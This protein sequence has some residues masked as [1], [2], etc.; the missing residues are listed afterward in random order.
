MSPSVS[1]L[2]TV[3]FDLETRK[4]ASDVGGWD[5]MRAGRGGISVLVIWDSQ[6][7]RYHL[8]DETTLEAAAEHLEAA[9]V[10]LS[11]N[12]AGFDVPV[13]E[14]LIQRRLCLPQ[15]YDLLKLIWDALPH[16][17]KGHTL[18]EV[19]ERTLNQRKT[20]ESVLAPALFDQGRFAEL[21]DYCISDVHLTL[22]LFQFVQ[23]EGGVIG[24]SGN[25]LTLSLPDW[26]GQVT[27]HGCSK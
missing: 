7:G 24:V 4:L 8:Y 9:D 5:A 22:R 1:T 23:K 27:L 19:G 11:F 12:G 18:G 15:H 2:R 20:G 17:Q 16:R 6:S 26:F 25:L 14:G 21:H 13:I 10:V 3:V